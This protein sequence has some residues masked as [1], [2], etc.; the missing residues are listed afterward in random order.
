MCCR[1]DAEREAACDPVSRLSECAREL[2]R[3]QR[4]LPGGVAASDDRESR[5]VEQTDI[6]DRMQCGRGVGDLQ[7]LPG[8]VTVAERKK[9]VPGLGE[10]C[11]GGCKEIPGWTR[12]QG[13]GG[14]RAGD[15]GEGRSRRCTYGVG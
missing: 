10:P 9:V 6:A 14:L 7:K 1:V 2:L 15:V 4:A 8:I 5:P 11:Q 3:I 12:D 13:I